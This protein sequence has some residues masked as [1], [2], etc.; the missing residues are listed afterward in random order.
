MAS[1]LEKVAQEIF[2]KSFQ[3][4]TP[5]QQEYTRLQNTLELRKKY[6]EK[7]YGVEIDYELEKPDRITK[8]FLKRKR[9]EMGRNREKFIEE[10]KEEETDLAIPWEQEVYNVIEN[11]KAE[12]LDAPDNKELCLA[13]AEQ[14]DYFLAYKCDELEARQFIKNYEDNKDYLVSL[15]GTI[16]Y[17]SGDKTGRPQLDKSFELLD[18]LF[19]GIMEYDKSDIYSACDADMSVRSNSYKYSALD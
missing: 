7:Q 18:I 10:Y 16:K 19:E 2:E 3:D 8:P 14:L 13:I 15:Y 5:N 11:I 6:A 4:L 1:R 9:K 17:D 12:L